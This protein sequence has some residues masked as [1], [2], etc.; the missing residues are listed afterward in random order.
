MNNQT[1]VSIKFSNKITNEK[2]LE[3]YAETLK[4]IKAVLSGMDEEKIKNLDESVKNVK[5]IKNEAKEAAKNFNLAFNYTALR[6]FTRIMQST[7]RTMSRMITKSSEYAENINLYQVAFKGSYQEAD[8]FINKLT[9]MYG[10]DESWLTKTVGLFKQL[11]NAMGLSVEEGTRL[12][13][14]LTQMSVDI[15]SLYNIDVDKAA[16]VL[17]SALAGQTKPIRGATGGDITVPTLQTTLDTLGIQRYAS[18]LSYSE[19][20]L[21]IIISLTKQLSAATNDFGK[22]IESPANQMRILNEQWSR[23][24]RAIGNVFMPLVSKLLPILNGI[25]MALVEIINLIASLFGYDIG[26]YDYGVGELSDSFL[27]LEDN[28]DGAAESAKK[29]KSGLRGFDKLNVITTPSDSGKSGAS[30]ID[31]AIMNAFNDAFDEY[32]SKLK[33]VQMKATKIRDTIMEW[34][35]FTKQ[36]DK[37]TGKVSF[38]FDHLTSGTVLGAL[39]VGGTI[40]SGFV[41]ISK[42]LAK[43]GIISKPLPGIFTLLGKAVK[44]ILVALKALWGVLVAIV[45]AIAAAT[46]LSVG[47]VVAIGVAIAAA[48]ALIWVFRDEIFEFFSNLWEGFCEYIVNPIVEFLT[49]IAEWIYN[50]VI[51]PVVSFIAQI[52]DAV[53]SIFVTI[54]KNTIDIVV[55]I[56]KGIATIIAKIIEIYA[57]IVEIFVALGKAFYTYVIKPIWEDFIK[58]FFKGVYDI[59][60]KPIAEKIKEAATFIND[61]FITPIWE[62]AKFVF[63]IIWEGIKFILDKIIWLK[64]KAIEIFKIV[65]I[66]VAD[67]ISGM[68]KG[69]IN[70]IFAAIEGAINFFIRM[71]NG[72]IDLINNIPGVDISRVSELRI[73]RLKVGLDFVPN[74]YYP[75]YLDYG[76][77]VLTKEE[78][79]DY[80]AHLQGLDNDS[81]KQTF[82]PT[83]IIQVGDEK[84][85]NVVLENLQDMA[86]TNGKPIVIGGA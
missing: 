54:T 30:G 22:T 28:I 59:V 42:I 51:E 39:A 15:S 40:Y 45:E 62:G 23:L 76:E 69:V 47:W 1:D 38:K 68:I 29:L 32:N 26:D 4:T 57:K 49:G 37:E 79:R 73:P 3:K 36:I 81:K 66:A 61:F 19:K 64:D 33:E 86:T 67:F 85:T 41:T 48:I 50:V 21:L 60:I 46:G 71:L 78:N 34:L 52:L 44:G 83:F 65:G 56:T 43:V 75:A 9:E 16:S 82:N 13:T 58:P 53:I 77:R 84:L 31:P 11:S 6:T 35:G 7:V 25:I 80:T 74:D 12:S 70:G 8:K 55:G 24:T 5:E 10:L 20:R 2:N 27:D 18:E 63:N 17:Q 72:A 14:L